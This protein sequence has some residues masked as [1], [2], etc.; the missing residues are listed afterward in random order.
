MFESPWVTALVVIVLFMAIIVEPIKRFVHY[1]NRY[2]EAFKNPQTLEQWKVYWQNKPDNELRG[3][4]EGHGEFS[5]EA[6]EAAQAVLERR[7]KMSSDWED[8]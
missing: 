2:S 4:A 3:A 7:E 5:D 1:T 8:D 6:R